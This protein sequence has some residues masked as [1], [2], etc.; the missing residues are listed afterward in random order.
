MEQ[1]F[2]KQY[3]DKYF[4]QLVVRTTTLL[5]DSNRPLSYLY[6]QLFTPSY[7]VDGRWSSVMGKFTRVAADVVAMD[8][9]LPLVKRDP[10]EVVTGDIPK[11]GLS[12]SLNEKQMSDIDAMIAMRR[13]E[14]QIAGVIFEDTPKVIEAVY[15]RLE[16]MALLGL[17]TGVATAANPNNVGTEI[18]VNYGFKAENQFLAKT[19][20]WKGNASTATPLSDIKQVIDKADEDGNT[21]I[22]VYADDEWIDAACASEEVRAY[23]A[24]ALNGT[25]VANT[26]NIPIL[27]REQLGAILSRKYNIELVRVNRSVRTEK[28]G[29][30]TSVKPWKKG[31]ATFVCDERVGDLVWTDVA[32]NNR[33]VN[34]VDYQTAS[35]FI[36]VSKYREHNPIRELTSSQARVVPVISN[37]DRI[38]T[39]DSTI[40]SE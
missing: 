15:E 18:R 25:S 36:L 14:L 8:S 32:E 30:Q 3:V 35:D 12:L 13:P 40:V 31:S 24:F 17:S 22:R 28:N 29:V 39:L 9:P 37:V 33:R 1:S 7:S 5:N 6:R 23:F 19:A 21:I 16:Y 38:Y 2:Y 20:I 34:G 10:I 4:P 11:L 26:S 27:D